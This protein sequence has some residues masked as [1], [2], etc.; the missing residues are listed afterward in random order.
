MK[1]FFNWYLLL[2]TAIASGELSA[3]LT[4]LEEKLYND[5]INQ[6]KA[7]VTKE[8][9]EQ[10]LRSASDAQKK[11]LLYYQRYQEILDATNLWRGVRS[12]D[13]TA[14]GIHLLGLKDAATLASARSDALAATELASFEKFLNLFAIAPESK[15]QL[16]SN[17]STLSQQ[18][19][20]TIK[21]M[22]QVVKN[23]PDVDKKLT[24][25]FFKQQYSFDKDAQLK[26][27]FEGK[28]GESDGLDFLEK[29]TVDPTE[30][31]LIKLLRMEYL[32]QPTE[33]KEKLFT[34]IASTLDERRKIYE[35]AGD[36]GEKILKESLKKKDLATAVDT[37]VLSE[38]LRSER[39]G[40]PIAPEIR[41]LGAQIH[42]N[43]TAF[44]NDFFIK[45]ELEKKDTYKAQSHNPHV[46]RERACDLFI[47]VGRLDMKQSLQQAPH[48]VKFLA[49]IPVRAEKMY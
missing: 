36:A 4:Y 24:Q 38:Y 47:Q 40:T 6:E 20:N 27:L 48:A 5:L 45:N 34:L 9:F 12:Q 37:L 39:T 29:L 30:N 43:F 10:T 11:F 2:G 33:G 17:A 13:K 49:S 14:Q 16:K 8:L 35:K 1:T 3:R 41:R 32:N 28:I 19:Q 15:K 18:M 44:L 26:R 42:K 23:D 25:D 31:A 46:A 7:T 21:A 22:A